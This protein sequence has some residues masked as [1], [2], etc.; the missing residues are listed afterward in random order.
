MNDRVSLE[1][2]RGDVDVGGDNVGP[3]DDDEDEEDGGK[4]YAY[5]GYCPGSGPDD[6]D[7]DGDGK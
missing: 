5:S 6:E 3:Q 4:K 7:D 1:D 2:D